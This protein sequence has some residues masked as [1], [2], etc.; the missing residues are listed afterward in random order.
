[1]RTHRFGCGVAVACADRIDDPLLL[2]ERQFLG[3][4][5]ADHRPVVSARPSEQ[6]LDDRRKIGFP[7]I[8]AFSR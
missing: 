1:M 7:L 6:R 4:R 8:C 5:R 3:A 2:R